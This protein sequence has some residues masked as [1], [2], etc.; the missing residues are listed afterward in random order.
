MNK[1]YLYYT[2]FYILSCKI[3]NSF[4]RK[5]YHEYDINYHDSNKSCITEIDCNTTSMFCNKTTLK[6][7]CSRFYTW[8]DTIRTCQFGF[9]NMVGWY[10]KQKFEDDF[11]Y[12]NASNVTIIPNEIFKE[13]IPSWWIVIVMSIG[14]LCFLSCIVYVCYGHQEIDENKTV[15]A[16]LFKQHEQTH[17]IQ[18][19]VIENI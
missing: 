9:N 17:R 8:N 6:C 13:V 5:E 18:T 11:S 19:S 10:T 3:C 12:T 7:Y 2:F 14:A 16:A 15:F 1:K 4:T